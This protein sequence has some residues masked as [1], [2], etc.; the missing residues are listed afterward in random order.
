[1]QKNI[2]T[3]NVQVYKLTCVAALLA[4]CVSTLCFPKAGIT[5]SS[6]VVVFERDSSSSNG[7]EYSHVAFIDLSNVIM[8][9]TCNT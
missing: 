6:A 9:R 7:R 2:K 3:F 8:I 1:M 5:E 4:V